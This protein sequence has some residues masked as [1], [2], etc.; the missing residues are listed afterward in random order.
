MSLLCHSAPVNIGVHVS[1][2]IVVLFRYMPRSGIAGS[3]GI[4]LLSFLRNTVFHSGCT[5]LHSYQQWRRVP[6]S[7]YPLQHLL[8]ADLLMMAILTGVKWY[9]IVVLICLSVILSEVEHFFMYLLFIYISSLEKCLF[10]SFHFSFGLFFCCWVV[11]VV[12]VF[13]R[14]S[15]CQLHHLQ[16]FSPILQVVFSG[17]L[18]FPL[19]CKSL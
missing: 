6:F 8:F 7:P 18:R 3:Y 2:W 16:L 17:F 12:C 14:L 19:L 5:N 10:R 4:S 11:W 13:W 1:F 15:P 9:I